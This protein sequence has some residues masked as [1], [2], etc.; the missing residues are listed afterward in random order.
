ML[1]TNIDKVIAGRSGVCVF[2]PLCG[3][4]VDMK[5]YKKSHLMFTLLVIISDMY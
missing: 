1:E 4:A 2:V 3:K 5:W